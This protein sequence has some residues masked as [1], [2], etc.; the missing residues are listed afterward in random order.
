MY[1]QIIMINKI[2]NKHM[3]TVRN[4]FVILKTLKVKINKI[5]KTMKITTRY[6]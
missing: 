5:M 1:A 2:Q 6:N 3:K 4:I